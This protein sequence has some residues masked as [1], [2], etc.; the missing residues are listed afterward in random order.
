MSLVNRLD[1]I[2]NPLLNTPIKNKSTLLIGHHL[3]EGKI[4]N[5]AKPLAVLLRSRT[6]SN[7]TLSQTVRQ[8]QNDEDVEILHHDQ[9]DQQTIS[10]TAMEWNMIAL[11]K[12]KIV[13]SKR[14]MPVVN[15][16]ARAAA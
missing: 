14:P 4:T 8:D 15:L 7:V 16:T 11:V 13:F 5:I 12:R 9:E 10:R 6:A 3:L 2:P 1:A